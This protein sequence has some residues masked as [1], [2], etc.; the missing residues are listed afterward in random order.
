MKLK[1]LFGIVLVGAVFDRTPSPGTNQGTS[2]PSAVGRWSQ[3]R[4]LDLESSIDPVDFR[5]D[6]LK[7]RSTTVAEPTLVRRRNHSRRIDHHL[8]R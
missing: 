2:P 8:P 4:T 6:A 3:A 5:V 1:M 7:T